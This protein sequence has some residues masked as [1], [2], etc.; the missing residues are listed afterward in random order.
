MQ[1]RSDTLGLN[2]RLGTRMKITDGTREVLTVGDLVCVIG[3][4]RAEQRAA[5]PDHAS[6]QGLPEGPLYIA[7]YEDSSSISTVVL[8]ESEIEPVE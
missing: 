5:E 6:W 8:H 3:V 2:Y 7:E 1:G 4:V